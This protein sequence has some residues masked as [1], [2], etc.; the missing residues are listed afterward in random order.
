MKWQEINL[1]TK[2]HLPR[3]SRTFKQGISAG[4]EVGTRRRW[5]C[6]SRSWLYWG[7]CTEVVHVAACYIL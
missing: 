4:C 6:R 3:K 5:T 7:G 2:T 1:P